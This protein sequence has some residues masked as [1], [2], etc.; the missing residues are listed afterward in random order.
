MPILVPLNTFKTL[1][2][3]VTDDVIA[4]PTAPPAPT[5]V[6]TT[7][8]GVSTV[9]LLS[10]FSNYTATNVTVSAVMYRAATYSWL[11]K[12]FTIPAYDAGT[13]LTGRLVLEEGNRLYVRASAA[14]SVNFIFSYLE[15]ANA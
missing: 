11:I 3:A 1:T 15:T 2:H 8:A 5:L 14:S 7:G 9:V 12:D 6:Y 10:Q 13:I 4:L